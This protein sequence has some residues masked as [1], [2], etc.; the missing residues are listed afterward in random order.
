MDNLLY[1]MLLLALG[2]LSRRLPAFPENTPQV[3]NQYVIWIS[4]PATVLLKLNGLAFDTRLLVL[5]LVP[6]TLL[7]L[8]IGAVFLISRALGWDRPLTGAVLLSVALGNTSFFGFPAVAAFWGE[9]NLKYAI[10][11]DQ[12][13]SFLA[14]A[15]FGT[16]VMSVYGNASRVTLKTVLLRI[17]G[18]PPFTALV[19]GIVL[20]RV[21]IPATPLLVLRGLAATLIPLV[22]FSVGAQLRFRQPLSNVGPIL[23]TMGLKMVVSPMIAMGLLLLFGISGPVYQVTVFEAA[24]PSMVMAG[25]LASAGNLRADVANA[26]IGYGILFSFVTL[27]F[28]YWLIR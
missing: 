25:I 9:Q 24:M 6:W 8:S 13:G 16:I 17:L 28:F 18:F 10:L 11:Y 14:V 4:F 20:S 23:I 27:P 15:T 2:N 21:P 7:F 1:L 3:L 12:L 22:I 5:V 19:L 26:A